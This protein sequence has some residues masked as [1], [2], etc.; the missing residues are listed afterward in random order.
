M[1]LGDCEGKSVGNRTKYRGKGTRF[2]WKCGGSG[3]FLNL[4]N[5]DFALRIVENEEIICRLFG[6]LRKKR[7]QRLTASS[8]QSFLS[9]GTHRRPLDGISLN[10]VFG[11]FR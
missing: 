8:F 4:F 3:L 11:T 7:E 10:F 6:L 2:K 5:C 9:H 1:Y